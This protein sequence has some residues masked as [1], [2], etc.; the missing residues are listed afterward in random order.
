[1][2]TTKAGS[3]GREMLTHYDNVSGRNRIK[4][5]YVWA[6]WAFAGG[7]VV[8]VTMAHLL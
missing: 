5:R 2:L 8:G 4:R 7:V 1:M 6:L 3:K